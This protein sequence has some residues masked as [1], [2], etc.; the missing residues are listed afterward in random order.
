MTTTEQV[1][2]PPPLRL[3]EDW[4]I[5]AHERLNLAYQQSPHLHFDDHS[6]L[7]FFSDM[8]R[9]EK[10]RY[11]F[12]APNEG[13]FLHALHYYYDRN[14]TYVELG[15]GDELWY[16]NFAV[17][18]RAY[19]QL[20]ELLHQ[21]RASHRLH[22]IIGNHDSVRGMF[23]PMEK[24]GIPVHQGLVL[25]HTPSGHN[26]FAVHGH[27]AHPNGDRHWWF[28]R[29]HSRYFVKYT[30]PFTA[31]RYYFSEPAIGLPTRQRLT[32]FPRRVSDRVLRFAWALEGAILSWARERRQAIICGHT[33]L[34]A[35]PGTPTSAPEPPFINIG[36]C[37]TPG[38]ITGLEIANGE[39]ALVKWKPTGQGDYART[40]LGRMAITAV[41]P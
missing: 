22:L 30:L 6:R 40:V 14:F 15:D 38:Y 19:S 29:P 28:Q 34:C 7:I 20:F 36:H 2:S 33:H 41:W 16:N 23:D 31:N 5:Q 26:L 12:F 25:H 3:W 39:M 9:G 11:D 21:F 1:L 4:H 10:D 18:R 27:Q 17:I 35:F 13:L 37:S 32:N 8:H 24:E